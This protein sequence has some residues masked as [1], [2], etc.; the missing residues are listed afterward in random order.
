MTDGQHVRTLLTWHDSPLDPKLKWKRRRKIGGLF[1]LTDGLWGKTYPKCGSADAVLPFFSCG[2]SMRF[3]DDVEGWT[4]HK[5]LRSINTKDD[6]VLIP[7]PW[8]LAIC[9]LFSPSFLVGCD[10]S[11]TTNSPNGIGYW[12]HLIMNGCCAPVCSRILIATLHC[13]SYR[14]W[15]KTI[16]R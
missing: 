1:W 14:D 12:M 5:K 10:L 3:T 7:I 11:N 8:L 15:S 9:Y 13:R 16:T 6:L 4:H 2:S